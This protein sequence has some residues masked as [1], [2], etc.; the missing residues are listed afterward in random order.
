MR[1]T[2][3]FSDAGVYGWSKKIGFFDGLGPDRGV[4][5]IVGDEGEDEEGEAVS[6]KAKPCEKGE[7]L[8]GPVFVTKG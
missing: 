5:A 7:C 6:H 8:D 1:G 3:S 2:G 4:A